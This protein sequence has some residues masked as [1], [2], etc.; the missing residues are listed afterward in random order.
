[1]D[2]FKSSDKFGEVNNIQD[3][4]REAFE[5][6][7][8]DNINFKFMEKTKNCQD[9]AEHNFIRSILH[10]SRNNPT[11]D[12]EGSKCDEVFSEYLV[13]VS[14]IVNDNFFSKVVKFVF[15]FR[16]CLNDMHKDDKDLEENLYY[17][18]CKNA[19]DAPDIS[20]DF[21]T[22]YLDFNDNE[23]YGFAKEDAIDL[24]QNFCQWLYD[25]NFTCSKL[26]LINNNNY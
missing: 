18:E 20:N 7:M 10:N 12:G 9:Y 23:K 21:V 3:I 16:E 15:L 22:D 5:E 4:L 8:T 2:Y 26:S 14:K 19:E 6:L 17:S 11:L 1:M 13:K 25:N 24:T